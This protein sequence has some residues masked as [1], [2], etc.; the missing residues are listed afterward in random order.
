MLNLR[1]PYVG[2]SPDW[3]VWHPEAEVSANGVAKLVEKATDWIRKKMGLIA[4]IYIYIFNAILMDTNPWDFQ[5]DV[6]GY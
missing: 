6:D 2:C 1:K 3:W 4:T 5:W